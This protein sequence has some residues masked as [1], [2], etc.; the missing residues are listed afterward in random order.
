[1]ITLARLTDFITSLQSGTS[2]EETQAAQLDTVS[3]AVMRTA[4]PQSSLLHQTGLFVNYI[5]TKCSFLL[6]SFKTHFMYLSVS[7]VLDNM[8]TDWSDW[9]TLEK[10]GPPASWRLSSSHYV[11]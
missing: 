8:R 9:S 3:V 4:A 1:M 6:H 5:L 11:N 7:A 10:L 2:G